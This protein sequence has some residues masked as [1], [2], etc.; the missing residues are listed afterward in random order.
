MASETLSASEIESY[1]FA[2]KK[3]QTIGQLRLV[4]YACNKNYQN[5][6]N[7]KTTSKQQKERGPR[8]PHPNY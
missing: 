4:Y 3:V 6:L 8:D 1:I 7:I 2:S 5:N